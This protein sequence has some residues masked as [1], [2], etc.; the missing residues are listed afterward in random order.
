MRKS[1][2][3]MNKFWFY[4]LNLTWGLPLNIIGAC[5]ALALLITGHKPKRFA[6]CVYFEVGD[7][8]GGF[9]LGIFFVCAKSMP[10]SLKCHEFGHAIQNCYF[11][12]LMPFVVSI[13][14]AIRYWYREF[15]YYR[16]NKIPATKYDDIWFEK[17]ATELGFKQVKKELHIYE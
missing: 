13:P 7:D 2:F 9:E 11:G 3:S 10:I 1:F 15:K 16:Q 8:W 5:V 17:Q 4:F 14:S 12:P 6:Y